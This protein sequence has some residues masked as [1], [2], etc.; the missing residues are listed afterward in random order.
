M[1]H[2]APA[3][4]VDV[5]YG[6]QG[7]ATAALVT[8]R[9][10]TFS[11]A[12]S[13]HVAVVPETEDYEPGGLYRRELPCILAVV[14]LAPPLGLLVVDGYATLDPDGRPGLGARAADALGIPVIG[15]AKKPFRTATH[16]VKVLRGQA[17]K[18]LYVTTAG[19]LD[20]DAAAQIVATMAGPH[21]LPSAIRRVDQL[22]RGTTEPRSQ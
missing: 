18:P 14:T 15:V 4:V 10:P 22:A 20:V 21:R 5:H 9:D 11:V 7:R 1:T 2:D 16:A 13:E 3:G 8:S 17:T 12:D 19:G 6:A